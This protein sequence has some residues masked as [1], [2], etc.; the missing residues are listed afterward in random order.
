MNI[1]K[2]TILTGATL[3]GSLLA[4]NAYAQDRFN[5]DDK[6][7]VVKQEKTVSLTDD[8]KTV[9]NKLD[10][11]LRGSLQV[12][13][14][15][16]PLVDRI[17]GNAYFELR[18]G[19]LRPFIGIQDVF[20]KYDNIDGSK[21]EVNSVREMAGLGMYLESSKEFESFFRLVLGNENSKFNDAIDMDAQRFIYGGE[22]G[23]ASVEHGYKFLG[24]I[25][26]GTGKFDAK[27]NSGYEIDGDFDTTYAGVEGRVA[28]KRDGKKSATSSEFDKRQDERDANF[29]ID[30]LVDFSWNENKFGKLETDQTYALKLGPSFTWN[31]RKEDGTGEI[32][33]VTPYFMFKQTD[34][35]SG[36]SLRETQTETTGGGVQ[37]VYSFNK[38]LSLGAGA[39]YNGSTQSIDDPGQNFDKTDKKNGLTG[40]LWFK[41]DF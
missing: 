12:K 13:A 38:N 6:P 5:E 8:D 25:Y 40:A 34:T 19:R 14:E 3:L 2:K 16:E 30:A 33:T 17:S 7:A 39:G 24:K 21:L 18:T 37:A 15:T 26:K 23:I 32:L 11:M 36:I 10:N 9:S 35:E 41:I 4:S 22:F 27:L 1:F 31:S 20:E 28:L 29:S